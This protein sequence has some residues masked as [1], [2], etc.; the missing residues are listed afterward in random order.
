MIISLLLVS[1]QS[2]IRRGCLR[3]TDVMMWAN[4]HGVSWIIQKAADGP[5]FG[6]RCLL[7]GALTGIADDDQRVQLCQQRS[8]E[9]HIPGRGM[10]V[11]HGNGVA[12][13]LLDE[14][15]E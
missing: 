10:S 6:N 13:P 5:Y 8:I 2:F 14:L 9:Q 3:M 4:E 15:R 11:Q 1:P 7:M 12:G